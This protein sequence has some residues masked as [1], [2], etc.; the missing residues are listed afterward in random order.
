MF[1]TL[2][3]GTRLETTEATM[4]EME[5]IVRAEVPEIENLLLNV[6]SGGRFS[7]GGSNRGQITVTFPTVGERTSDPRDVETALRGAG[8]RFP[9]VEIRFSQNQGRGLSGGSPIDV[10]IESDDYDAAVEVAYEVQ[11]LIAEEFPEITE[12]EVSADSA[13]PELQLRIDRERAYDFGFTV[14][15][16]ASEVRANID[17]T[18]A[19]VFRSGGDEL[20]IRAALRRE[21]REDTPDLES[22]FLRTSS[23]ELVPVSN[24]ASFHRG[25]GPVSIERENEQRTVHVTAG[26]A[27]GT[28]AAEIQP[29]LEASLRDS[30]PVPRGT[31]VRFSGEVSAI[32][33]TG[34]QFLIVLAVAVALV[35]AVMASQFESFKAP[36]IIFFTIPMMLIGVL[37]LYFLLGEPLSMFSLV[38]LV[39]LAGIVVNNGI[40]LVDYTNLL[41]A[42]GIEVRQACV[43][44]G[45]SR[46]RPVLMTTFTTILG[47]VPLAFFPGEG[48]A[49]TQPVGMTIVGGLV[50]STAVT[51]F[52][53][54]VL[55]SLIEGRGKVRHIDPVGE[56]A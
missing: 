5:E 40:V 10:V 39:M 49:I 17:G 52:L 7:A 42:R 53:I 37:W 26:L 21:D 1:L 13:L 16:I 38:G 50:S 34:S 2:P 27:P 43:D 25:A 6:G 33:E 48:A 46:L 32:E 28:E 4:L 45:R 19:G 47:M 51:L 35:F 30:I 9:G 56:T 23:G 18:T 20:L 41:R 44:A 3:Q 8:D 36:F 54:P 29:R 12:P 24:F 15:A 22:I 11:R 14:S 55:Y 31:T